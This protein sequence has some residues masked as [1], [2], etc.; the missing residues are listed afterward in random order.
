MKRITTNVDPV[1][2]ARLDELA[3]RDGV[4]TATLLREA[5]ERYV[6][7]RE[8]SLEPAPLPD[9]VGMFE[10]DGEPVAERVD[11]IL[12]DVVDEIY[13]TEF[14]GEPKPSTPDAAGGRR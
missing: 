12:G 14:L 5:M 8:T 10:G 7:E 4:P 3:Q 11:E 13:R 9:W 1:T 6:T 2:Y